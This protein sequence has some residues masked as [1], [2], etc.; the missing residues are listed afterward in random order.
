MKR[1]ISFSLFFSLTFFFALKIFSQ[2]G[3]DPHWGAEYTIPKINPNAA[4][5]GGVPNNLVVL[6]NGTCINFYNEQ[7]PFPGG[8][9]KC[10]YAGTSNHGV[11]W[12]APSPTLVPPINKTIANGGSVGAAAD[13][14]GN[15]HISWVSHSPQ[16]VFYAK[17]TYATQTW[18]DT[19]RVSQ[20]VERQL[21][22]QMITVDRNNRIHITWMDGKTESV[23]TSEVMYSR[24]IN[25]GVS[26]LS[27][28]QLS[29]ADGKHSAFPMGDFS[30]TNSD[31]LAV[32][33]RDST[34]GGQ[35]WDVVIARTLNGGQS[36][37]P[38]IIVA[39][40]TGIQSDPN[41]I[42]DKNQVMHILYHEYY[43]AGCMSA[44]CAKVMYGYSTNNGVTWNPSGFRQLSPANI[45]AHLTKT[46]YD[47]VNNVFWATYKDERDFNFTTGNPQADL[48][49][50]Y[51]L[52]GGT[53]ISPVNEFVTDKDSLEVGYHNF[54]VGNDGILRATFRSPDGS[55]SAPNSQRYKERQTIVSV[56][57]SNSALVSFSLQQNFPN[58]FNPETN[59]QFSLGK[60]ELITL[61]VYDILGNEVAELLNGK[62][63]EGH[64]TV[65]FNAANFPSGTYFYQLKAENFIETKKMILL[66]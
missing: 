47:Y 8:P 2:H 26:F 57:E 60:K 44:L 16:G 32:A 53:Y 31:T 52:N 50:V 54:A 55:N 66:K 46:A 5:G 36:W 17:W 11:N 63:N 43:T 56:G 12:N 1:I 19:L 37:L 22:Y 59:I 39:G 64:Q 51:I 6:P 38:Q 13:K 33:W 45:R 14:D 21:S 24:S 42:I 48:A 15:I 10:Y 49:A 30:G 27:Q 3:I 34:G 58:P 7:F 18:S 20:R 4:A 40:G 25:E 9:M 28:I 23:L 65:K 41:L 35:Q 62:M 61:K 29:N